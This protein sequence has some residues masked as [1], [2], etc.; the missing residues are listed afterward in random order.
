MVSKYKYIL[1]AITTFSQPWGT[2]YT[3]N[4]EIITIPLNNEP[5]LFSPF[6]IL[7]PLPFSHAKTF[8]CGLLKLRWPHQL[9]FL[10]YGPDR[11]TNLRNPNII[12]IFVWV[13]RPII[14]KIQEKI[15]LFLMYKILFSYMCFK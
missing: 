12:N 2:N 6:P 11:P 13:D 3:L 5:L 15:I 9:F 7:S 4:I 10:D 14:F 8:R 1:I